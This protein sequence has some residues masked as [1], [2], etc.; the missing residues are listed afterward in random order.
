MLMQKELS[1]NHVFDINLWFE[2]RL[3]NYLISY[4]KDTGKDD[5]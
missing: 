4:I 5:T 1:S 3:V 2:L